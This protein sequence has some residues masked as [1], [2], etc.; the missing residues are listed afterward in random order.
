[1]RETSPLR[2]SILI[3]R[4]YFVRIVILTLGG[5]TMEG[6]DDGMSLGRTLSAVPTRRTTIS[7]EAAVQVGATPRGRLLDNILSP[8]RT[9]SASNR[10]GDPPWSPTCASST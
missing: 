1:M 5:A 2:F 8:G 3:R 4:T 6:R 7:S 9:L 10:R